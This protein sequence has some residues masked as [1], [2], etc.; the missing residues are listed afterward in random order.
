MASSLPHISPHSSA[1]VA[2]TWVS[3]AVAIAATTVGIAY[4]PVDSWTRA[5]V[6]M[7]LLFTIGSTLNLAKTTRDL[8]EFQRLSTRVD[9]ARV[10]KLIAQ[11]DPLR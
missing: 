7:G 1:W 2:Q 10:E 6:G 5:F 8:H 3:F 9:E 11:H 4:L